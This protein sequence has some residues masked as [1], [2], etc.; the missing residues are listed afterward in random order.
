MLHKVV[1]EKVNGFIRVYDIFNTSAGYSLLYHFL[2]NAIHH[3]GVRRI[4]FCLLVND[5]ADGKIAPAVFEAVQRELERRGKGR[6]RHSGVHL[7]SGKIK[8]GQCGSWYGSKVWHSTDKYRQVIWQCNHKFDNDERCSTPHFTDDEIKAYFV[9]AVNKL[10]PEKHRI[11]KAFD[12]IKSTV[13][14]TSDLDA[15]KTALE[16]EMVIIS[17]MMQQSIYENAHV[18][19]DQTEYQKRYDGLTERY[20]KAKARLEEVTAVISDKATRQA[21]IEDFLRELQ[22]LDGLVAEFDPILWVSL[23]DFIT[24]RSKDDVRVTFKDGTEIRA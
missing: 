8:C 22:S 16:Q 18:A 5:R 6:N 13:L 19:L 23:V 3:F 11:I 15:E 24:V 1:A 9:S 21:T 7:F 14:D 20:D 4:A 12:T 17:E 10:L 2:Y